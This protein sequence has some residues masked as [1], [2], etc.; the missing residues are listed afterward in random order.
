LTVCEDHFFNGGLGIQERVD[1]FFFGFIFVNLMEF[2]NKND[3]KIYFLPHTCEHTLIN[4]DLI[5]Y[6][7]TS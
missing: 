6:M 7:Q 3:L 5:D 2:A 1:E 4:A